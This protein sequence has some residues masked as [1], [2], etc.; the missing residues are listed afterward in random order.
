VPLSCQVERDG[1]AVTFQPQ[2]RSVRTTI[3]PT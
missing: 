1:K 2:E 3:G